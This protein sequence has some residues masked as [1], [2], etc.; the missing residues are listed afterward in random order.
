LEA[1]AAG[2][3]GDGDSSVERNPSIIDGCAGYRWRQEN[4]LVLGSGL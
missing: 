2:V 1:A 4:V 3:A